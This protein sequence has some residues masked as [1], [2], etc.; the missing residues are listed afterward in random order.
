[1]PKQIGITETYDPCF[2]PDWE[3]KLLDANIIITKELNDEMIEKLLIVQDRVILHHTVTGQGGTILE[4]NVPTVE[5]EFEQFKKLLE[6]GFP[7]THYVLRLDPIILLSKE[8]QDNVVKV[9][10]L[11]SSVAKTYK[12]SIRCRISVVDMYPH[13]KERLEKAGVKVFYD[14]FT[15]P[16]AVFRRIEK[17]I[18]PYVNTH[19]NPGFF[20][21]SCAERKLNWFMVEPIGCAS[22][23]DL[24]LLGIE[25]F[26]RFEYNSPA[27]KQRSDCQCLAKKQILGVK[28]GRCPHNC[29]YCFW[30]DSQATTHD[31]TLKGVVTGVSY[32]SRTGE[33]TVK[34]IS[35]EEHA[36]NEQYRK[37]HESEN[38]HTDPKYRKGDMHGNWMKTVYGQ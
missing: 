34:T 5:H 38:V 15:A 30:K 26:D 10:E 37:E 9:L 18:A 29:L 20:F 17:L 24:E 25:S 33:R 19:E 8:T 31:P 36:A 35:P 22:T 4:P 6:R 27:K 1:M 28:P 13:V 16:D 2:V 32:D 3:T 14:T 7:Y 21:E 23:K 11:W 12:N